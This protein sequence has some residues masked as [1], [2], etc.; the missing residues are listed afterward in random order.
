M[1]ARFDLGELFNR[2]LS[3]R[4]SALARKTPRGEES[5][6]V[7][8]SRAELLKIMGNGAAPRETFAVA[9]SGEE[10]WVGAERQR[11]RGEPAR[12]QAGRRGDFARGP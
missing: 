5:A 12:S 7:V 3:R 2:A 11:R 9:G 10:A 8:D 1:E 6:R 4:K